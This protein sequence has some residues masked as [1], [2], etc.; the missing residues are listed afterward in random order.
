MNV[1]QFDRILRG[2]LGLVLVILPMTSAAS[3]ALY[4]TSWIYWGSVAI[5]AVLLLTA[6]FRFCPLYRLL[7]CSTRR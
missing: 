5:G 3:I 6:V 4:S 7:G 2:L 1:G